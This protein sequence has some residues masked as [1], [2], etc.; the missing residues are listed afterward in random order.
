[1][2]ITI[3]ES[4]N[5]TIFYLSKSVRVNG[6]ST[7]KS[8]ER[9]SIYKDVKKMV[10]EQAALEWADVYAVKRTAEEKNQIGFNKIC[11]EISKNHKFEFDLNDILLMLVYSRV[12]SPNSKRSSYE[13]SMTFLEQP[14]CKL[15]QIYRRLGIF[16]KENYFFQAKLYK[17]SERIVNRSKNVSYYD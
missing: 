3:S 13:Q 6:K 8:V 11:S 5:T 10:D 7:T 1:M 16:S 15:Y 12:I 17:S 14:T 2:K 9:I 4:K